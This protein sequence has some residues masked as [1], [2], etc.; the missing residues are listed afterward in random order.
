MPST[1][2]NMATAWRSYLMYH[3]ASIQIFFKNSV[4]AFLHSTVH[5]FWARCVQILFC[6]RNMEEQSECL[7]CGCSVAVL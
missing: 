7:N 5:A 3:H 6:H 4:N 2:I 1:L